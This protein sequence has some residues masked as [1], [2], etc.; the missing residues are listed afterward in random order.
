[1]TT[2]RLLITGATGLIGSVIYEM[3]QSIP[4]SYEVFTT[5]TSSVQRED[6]HHFIQ[7]LGELHQVTSLLD[8]IKPNIVIHTAAVTSVDKAELYKPLSRKLNVDVPEVIAKWCAS[9][10]ARLI[11]FSTDFVFEGTRLDYVETDQP[12]PLS[13]YGQTKLE[14]EQVVLE[15]CANSVVI[16]PILVYGSSPHLSRLNFPL[17]I[18][19]KLS[20]GESMNITADQYRMPTYVKDVAR[21]AIDAMV[22]GY[23]GILHLSGPNV[24]SVYDFALLV[25]EEFELDQS[26]LKPVT[27]DLMHQ[28]GRRPMK[29]GFNTKLAHEILQFEPLSP[30]EGLKDLHKSMT[31]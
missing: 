23:C 2:N 26:L 18:Q 16:R 4:G 21:A 20:N 11:H 9:N 10:E 6:S 7:D 25:A 24:L 27:T 8:R 28:T 3:L 30:A 14:S 13:W 22:C 19:A 15:S 29:S 31:S 12:A 5:S 1:M 17:L